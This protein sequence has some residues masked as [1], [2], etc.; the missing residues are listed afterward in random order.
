M[1]YENI[2]IR[3]RVKRTLIVHVMNFTEKKTESESH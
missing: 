1:D 3:G 2:S